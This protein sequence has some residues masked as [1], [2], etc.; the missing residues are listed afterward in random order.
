MGVQSQ[1]NQSD[2]HVA[3][4][5]QSGD[6]EA[7]GVLMERYE[8]KL[9]RYARRF[10]SEDRVEDLVQDVLVRAYEHINGFDVT[11]RFSPWMYRIAH[12]CFVNELRKKKG[13]FVLGLDLDSWLPDSS[14]ST[15]EDD[16]VDKEL[17]MALD[18]CIREVQPKQREVLILSYYEGLSYSE[19]SDVLHIPVAAVGMRISRGKKALKEIIKKRKDV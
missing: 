5:V 17:Q 14:M 8:K 6:T 1:D 16:A 10:L 7:F 18:S 12:N 4:Q 2:E 3:R 9:G 19:I 11:K 13:D 15:P